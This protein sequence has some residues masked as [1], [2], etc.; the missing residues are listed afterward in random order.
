MFVFCVCFIFYYY[1]NKINV[2]I[3][4]FFR[5]KYIKNDLYYGCFV[6]MRCTLFIFEER[7]LVYF[8]LQDIMEN[9][10]KYFLQRIENGEEIRYDDCVFINIYE[11]KGLG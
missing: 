2:L 9:E 5:D 11:F 8:F 7:I 4:L 6:I 1:K 3:Y 10:Y